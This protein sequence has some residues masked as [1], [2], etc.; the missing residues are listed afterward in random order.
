[1]D[2]YLLRR[3]FW[4]LNRYF[5]VPAFR[6]GLG[7]IMGNPFSGYI[8]VL[9]TTGRKTGKQRFTPVNY[10]ILD[11]KVYC[12]AGFGKAAHWYRN[13]QVEPQVELILPGGAMMGT[14]EDVLDQQERLVATRQVLKN[15]GFAGYF[16]GFSPHNVSDEKLY[17]TT[18]EVP[19]IRISPNG[20]GSGPGDPGGWLWAVVFGVTV[21]P[22]LHQ[23][24]KRLKRF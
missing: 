2:E 9:K 14:A 8:M 15:G 18:K 21:W 1:M 7:P 12:L 23:I 20:V 4:Y 22:V 6:L 10:A 17:E 3:I 16:Y 19:V 11:G 24:G 5:M 13:L